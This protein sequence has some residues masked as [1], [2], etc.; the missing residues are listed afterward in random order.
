MYRASIAFGLFLSATAF[1]E[2]KDSA[3]GIYSLTKI[4]DRHLSDDQSWTN[5]NIT[6]VII[7]TWW[8]FVEPSPQTF[9]WSYIDQGLALAQ[10]KNHNKKIAITV[11]AG[12]H[13]PDWIYTAGAQKFTIQGVGVMPCPWDPVFQSAWQQFVLALG[14]RYDSQAAVSYV[15]AE[16]PGRTEECYL[17]K[18]EADVEELDQDGGVKVWIQAAET[19]AGFYAAAFP[20]TPFVY[21]DGEPIPDD[22]TDYGTVVDYCV[23][24]F[25]AQFGIKSDGLRP[26]YP[27]NSYGA[28]EIPVLSPQHPV[29]FQDYGPFHEA[30]KLQQALNIGIELKAHFIEVL[31]SDVRAAYDQTVI[32]NAQS[33]LTGK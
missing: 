4:A 1:A 26:K 30:G 9:D 6:G 11:V 29:G 15:T 17:C 13:S 2:L 32:A 18:S 20:T 28:K 10:N 8:K 22:T 24:T 23:S 27:M 5:P 16:G 7:R 33:Q 19:I 31:S 12:L 25:G 21:A 14:T 3:H